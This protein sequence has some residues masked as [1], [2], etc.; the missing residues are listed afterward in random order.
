MFNSRYQAPRAESRGRQKAQHG[1]RAEEG[2][3]PSPPLGELLQKIP[4]NDILVDMDA[5][6]E[7]KITDSKYVSSYNWMK[8]ELPTIMIPGEL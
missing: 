2:R 6:K 3:S 4:A 1:Q 5:A 8:G 7:F